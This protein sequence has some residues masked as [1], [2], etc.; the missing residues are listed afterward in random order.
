[1]A[2]AHNRIGLSAAYV[3]KKSECSICG[4]R[5][6]ECSHISG[7][8]YEGQ[9]CYRLITEA[10]LLEVSLVGRPRDP[11]ARIERMSLGLA[12]LQGA[13]DVEFLPGTPVSCDRCLSPCEG[14]VNPYGSQ[15]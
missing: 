9:P 2:L 6:S 8:L 15:A 10:D 1:M 3:V 13:V 14:V 5:P 7:E 12:E 4:C 11:D